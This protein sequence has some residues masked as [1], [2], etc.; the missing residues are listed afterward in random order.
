MLR[1]RRWR[2]AKANRDLAEAR[3][4]RLEPPKD[5][6]GDTGGQLEA[7]EIV[8]DDRPQKSDGNRL[9]S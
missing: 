3:R 2:E 6:A 4:Q 9:K 5:D 7:E 8:F 1:A